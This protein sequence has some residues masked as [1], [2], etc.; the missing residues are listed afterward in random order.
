MKRER[1]HNSKYTEVQNVPKF[2][3]WLHNKIHNLQKLTEL[4]IVTI[5]Q[6]SCFP[7]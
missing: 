7:W 6:V 4:T 2:F 1:K 5:T 3:D